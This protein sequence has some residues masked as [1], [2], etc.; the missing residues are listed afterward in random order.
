M[1]MLALA[2]GV[3][4]LGAI[5][6][7]A[8]AYDLSRSPTPRAATVDLTAIHWDAPRVVRQPGWE[9]SVLTIP[10][11]TVVGRRIIERPAGV[12]EMQKP[13]RLPD[14]SRMHC[15]DWRDLQMGSGRVQTCE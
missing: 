12:A 7:T 11:I 9:R 13:E 4:G 14:I 8:L 3:W 6:A 2:L 10:P 15:T 1:K 5:S